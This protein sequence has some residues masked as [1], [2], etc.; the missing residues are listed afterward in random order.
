[1]V[2]AKHHLTHALFSHISM[3]S[4]VRR[5]NVDS[6]RGR[7]NTGGFVSVLLSPAAFAMT[8]YACA[9]AILLFFVFPEAAGSYTI[10]QAGGELSGKVSISPG[11][12]ELNVEP[13]EV[14]N[15]E[16]TVTNGTSEG[17]S[18]DFIVEDFEGSTE[19]DQ[20]LIYMGDDVSTWGATDWTTPEIDDIFLDQ[21]ESIT[22]NVEISVPENAGPGGRYAALS[23]VPSDGSGEGNGANGP[24][25]TVRTLF[26]LQVAGN[27]S[28][29]ASLGAPEPP[30]LFDSGRTRLGIV[31][32]NE[33]EVHLKPSGKVT[34]TNLLGQDVAVIDV[35]EWVVLPESSRRTLVAW[36]LGPLS[37]GRYTSQV[38]IDYGDDRTQLT[39]SNSFWLFPW[40]T[41][42]IIAAFL[43][44]V[45]VAIVLLR[46]RA[47]AK[48]GP[49]GQAEGL[50]TSE[51]GE[52]MVEPVPEVEAPIEGTMAPGAE[53]PALT[54]PAAQGQ[55]AA[56]APATQPVRE[57]DYVALNE[58]F[59]SME[60]SRLIDMHD[61][62][63]QS[64]VREL[65]SDQIEL[66]RLQLSEGGSEIGR[67]MLQEA[68]IAA[69]RARL[70]SVVGEIDDMLWQI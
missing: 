10:R 7:R 48:T 69:S 35:P 17:L 19:P 3:N 4:Y 60:D 24:D 28:E 29:A 66:A 65:I 57:T 67:E 44:A 46:R 50:T 38:V 61:T 54:E 27:A 11:K 52:G 14:T 40:D 13:G 53:E 58:L 49:P 56:G 41:L 45:V 59:P 42:A 39:A 30:G 26:L 63:T 70:Y 51:A 23:V 9:A 62:E 37:F 5:K 34:I 43:V 36:E 31:F 32:N 16:V 25:Q 55:Q 20:A 68:R 47:K 33:G 1:M 12:F 15:E 64:I 21:G 18:L 6:L 2:G 8:I 22:M